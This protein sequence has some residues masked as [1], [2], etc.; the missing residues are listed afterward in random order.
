[1]TGFNIIYIEQAS[2]VT[3]FTE[4]LILHQYPIKTQ[5]AC[6]II[7]TMLNTTLN[8]NHRLLCCRSHKYFDENSEQAIP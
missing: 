4:K 5:R 2:E 7:T 8:M 1:M 3:Y 6:Q